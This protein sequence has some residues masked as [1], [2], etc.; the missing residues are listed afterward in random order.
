MMSDLLE[1]VTVMLTTVLVMIIMLLWKAAT[2]R[3]RTGRFLKVLSL[4]GPLLVAVA[5]GVK[6]TQRM[7]L[8]DTTTPNG[9][10]IFYGVLLLTASVPMAVW[11]IRYRAVGCLEFAFVVASIAGILLTVAILV[12]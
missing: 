6:G 5:L 1:I 4:V 3:G 9:V 11:S 2:D 8:P 10:L 12:G 7:S